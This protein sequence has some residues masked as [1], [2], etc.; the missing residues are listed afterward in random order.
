MT[1]QMLYF[2]HMVINTYKILNTR[3]PIS[4]YSIF[5]LSRRKETLLITPFPTK[6]FVYNAC[7]IWNE[8]RELLSI[9]CFGVKTSNIKSDLKKYLYTRQNIGDQLEW[10]DENFLLR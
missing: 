6:N 2:Y 7:C 10:S 4:L 9:K 1:F 5:T 8:I 3:I